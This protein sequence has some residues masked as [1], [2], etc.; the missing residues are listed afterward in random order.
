MGR[1]LL[2]L[3]IVAAV[4]LV[5]RAFGPSTW[6]RNQVA[7]PPRQIKGPDDDEEFLW[8]IEK[9]RFKRRRAQ[10]AASK[11]EEE[12][13]KRARERY[14]EHEDESPEA[15]DKKGSGDEPGDQPEE[16]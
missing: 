6:K 13:M 7:A 11:E 5:W 15:G 14:L 8:N 1:L 3:L 2:L 12:R 10:E 16:K 4:I 9:N